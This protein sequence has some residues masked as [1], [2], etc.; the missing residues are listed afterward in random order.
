MSI[1]PIEDVYDALIGTPKPKAAGRG[2]KSKSSAMKEKLKE[3]SVRKKSAPEKMRSSDRDTAESNKTTRMSFSV[4]GK[5]A[6]DIRAY[7]ASRG[8][9][10]SAVIADAVE[11]Y[12]K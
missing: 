10:L 2:K 4:S 3:K 1:R 5:V 11:A 9:T 12:I 7:A 8:M 6:D